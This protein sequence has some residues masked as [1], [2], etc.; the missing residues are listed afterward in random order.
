MT[1]CRPNHPV[2]EG[3]RGSPH[4]NVS[5][6]D[7][8]DT[9]IITVSLSNHGTDLDDHRAGRRGRRGSRGGPGRARRPGERAGTGHAQRTADPLVHHHRAGRSPAG[10]PGPDRP[11]RATAPA[12]DRRGQTAAGG[13]P[14]H[15]RDPGRAGG[16]PPRRP[17]GGPPAPP[18]PRGPPDPPRRRGPPTTSCGRSPGCPTAARTPVPTRTRVP[19]GT[20]SGPRRPPWPA[21]TPT[22]TRTRTP[23]RTTTGHAPRI[24]PDRPLRCP[25]RRRPRWR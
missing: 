25:P 19:A 2:C 11:L 16:R 23:T 10:P 13:G 21:P 20:V 4:A 3:C 15:R 5:G 7:E 9:V 14:F 12:P 8:L 22:P 17:A 18:R 6:P 1:S 24:P